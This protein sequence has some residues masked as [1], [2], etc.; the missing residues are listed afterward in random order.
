M[1]DKLITVAGS[2]YT[3]RD[4]YRL[5]SNPR[6]AWV[7]KQPFS[8][9]GELQF[10]S[11]KTCPGNSSSE[12]GSRSSGYTALALAPSWPTEEGGNEDLHL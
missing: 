11:C 5:I 12:G 10:T 9:R 1:L 3:E 2:S 8:L 7:S 4:G 6:F